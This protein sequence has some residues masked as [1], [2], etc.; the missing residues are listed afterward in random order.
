[1]KNKCLKSLLAVMLATSM[2]S[3]TVF[4]EDD[5]YTEELDSA[6][7][8]HACLVTAEVASSY[9]V[10]IPK[11]MYLEKNEDGEYVHEY[12]I[13][14]DADI[15]I[16]EYIE[17]APQA[18]VTLSTVGKD[19]VIISVTQEVTKFR[20]SNYSEDLTDVTDTALV[21]STDTT[22]EATGS[23]AVKEGYSLSAGSWEGPLVFDISLKH[24]EVSD[25]DEG[26]ETV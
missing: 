5:V 20:G 16:D 18:E 23:L 9:T 2:F 4:A 25:T 12:E 24:D 19:D 11:T 15:D 6:E 13:D 7:G 14:V 10:A 17:V 3:M 26:G 1:M 22:A 21:D 8:S